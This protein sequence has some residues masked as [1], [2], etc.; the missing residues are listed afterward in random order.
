[1]K[2]SAS[3]A[4]PK[5]A[6]GP[7]TLGPL[8]AAGAYSLFLGDGNEQKY[9]LKRLKGL[10]LGWG[11]PAPIFSPRSSS[12]PK[13]RCEMLRGEPRVR[14]GGWVRGSGGAGVG[15]G[16]GTSRGRNVNKVGEINESPGSL[17][18]R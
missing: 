8:T 7:V 16:T 1:M 15:G 10:A 4:P 5:A 2:R 18:D 12:K 11:R 14:G 3:Q 17:G 6:R 13:P 9:C